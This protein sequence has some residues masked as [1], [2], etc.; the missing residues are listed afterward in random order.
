MQ[1][2][3]VQQALVHH[4]SDFHQCTY[5]NNITIIQKSLEGILVSMII[6]NAKSYLF[7]GTLFGN[8]RYRRPFFNCPRHNFGWDGSSAFK[9]S[10]NPVINSG[11]N[12]SESCLSRI[13][14]GQAVL[15]ACGS[16][17]PTDAYGTWT[18]FSWK[19]DEPQS[20]W[21]NILYANCKGWN[22]LGTNYESK[23]KYIGIDLSHCYRDTMICRHRNLRT[24]NA[25]ETC[26][27]LQL[28]FL[29]HDIYT[30]HKSM[31]EQ[32]QARKLNSA[33]NWEDL[34]LRYYT[35]A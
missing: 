21:W 31:K 34:S 7:G 11:Y 1:L 27:L 35:Q 8:I 24:T 29:S 22:Y 17:G 19:S 13:P 33:S 30:L 4:V 15:A 26:L 2:T 3:T 18:R 14:S 25:N 9:N 28:L 12:K 20:S 10:S 23:G 32:S 16:F 5:L 6:L